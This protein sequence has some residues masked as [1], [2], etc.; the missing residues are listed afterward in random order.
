[1]LNAILFVIQLLF[2]VIIGIYFFNMLKAQQSNK[3]AICK[4][5]KKE[6]EKLRKQR[7]IRLT[8]PLSEKTRPQKIDDIVG[9]EK[10]IRALKAAI[11]GPNPQHVLIYG[12]P[13]IG[14]TAAA[15][16]ILEEAKKSII[17]PFRENAKFVEIDATTLRFDER[18]IADPLIGS[19]HDPIY[20]GAGAYGPAGIPQ[21]K[22]GAVTRAHGGVLFIDEI[23]ELHSVQMN[24][25]LKVL[26]DRKVF[27]ESSYYNSE[28]YNIPAHIREIFENGLPADFRMV[29]A[30]TRLPEEIPPAIRSRC[31]EIFFR[32]LTKAEIKKIS[33]ISA[34]KGN[35]V[36]ESDV[37]DLIAKYAT[38]GRETVNIVQ[39]AGGMAM[40]DGRCMI[41]LEDVEW[42]IEFGR[43][44]PR[45]EKTVSDRLQI[46]CVNGLAIMG[47]SI[48]N[49]MDIEV[50]ATYI[51]DGRGKL[52]ITGIVEE[53]EINGRNTK[54]RRMS[55]A[56]GSIKNVFTVIKKYLDIDTD[57]Y[58]IHINFPGGMPVDGPSAGIAIL[59][60][61]YS[62]ILNKPISDRIAITGEISIKGKVKP[63][64][65]VV[66]KVQAAKEAGVQTVI[67]PKENWQE[68]FN[69]IGINVIPVDNMLQVISEVFKDEKEACNVTLIGDNI[70]TAS[71]S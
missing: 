46:G 34:T 39:S 45:F 14:K 21:P 57:D 71:V 51:G 23:G 55:T 3:S 37:E 15:R 2:S 52:S 48:G 62:A 36:I 68:T 66:E 42:V 56:K 7:E 63:V 22:P 59:T 53:E 60:C 41:R 64:G 47:N 58:E 38:N 1:M 6:L 19:V 5:S 40:L 54:L 44:S 25:L 8:E 35:F 24:R 33:K 31:I 49:V 50:S 32:P 30:T 11:C 20:Q 17:S 70:S 13:G 12:P 9:Q 69:F 10:G 16:V 29:G 4:E 27:F 65:G 67:I 26:E 43:Y 61:V 18:G 28:D